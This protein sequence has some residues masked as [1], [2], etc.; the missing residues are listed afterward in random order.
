MR[1]PDTPVLRAALPGDFAGVTA[2]LSANALPLDGV[3]S[4]LDDFLVAEQDGAIVGAIGLERYGGDALLRSAAVAA[5]VR[6]T[7]LG[8]RLVDA[9][10]DYAAQRHI[11]VLWLLTTTAEDWFPRFGFSVVSRREVPASVQGSREFKG[12]CPD[13]AIVMRRRA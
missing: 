13:S 6:G 10:L 2:L 1:L 5:P 11:H 9:I 3:P 12:A 8:S 7:G 4:S